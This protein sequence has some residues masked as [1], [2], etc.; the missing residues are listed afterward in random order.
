MHLG[1]LFWC[2][3]DPGCLNARE[4]EPGAG[5]AAEGGCPVST[6]ETQSGGPARPTGVPRW[7]LSLLD[8]KA[9]AVDE[10]DVHPFGVFVALCGHRLL[11]GGLHDEPLGALCLRC[12]Q[13][14]VQRRVD[15]CPVRWVRSPGDVRRHAVEHSEADRAAVTGRARALCGATL[16]REDLGLAAAPSPPLCFWCVVGT[17][18]DPLGPPQPDFP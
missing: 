1:H 11:M 16:P 4:R 5:A 17:T 3:V 8:F 12:S 10:G 9:H 6:P 14:V 2:A 15:G 13:A 7:A 18:V